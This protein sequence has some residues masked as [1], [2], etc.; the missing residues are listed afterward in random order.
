M[1]DIKKP[2]GPSDEGVVIVPMPTQPS[3]QGM[4]HQASG[5]GNSQV[6]YAPAS[7][8]PWAQVDYRFDLFYLFLVSVYRSALSALLPILTYFALA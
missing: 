6:A 5:Q 8:D 1:D 7:A 4:S 3:T 2:L